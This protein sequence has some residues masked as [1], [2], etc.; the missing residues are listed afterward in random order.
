MVDLR[1]LV[2]AVAAAV[3]MSAAS[4]SSVKRVL[5]LERAFPADQKVELEVLKARDR[6][7]HSRIMQSFAGG[8]ADFPVVGTS[9]PYLAG[10]YFTKVKLG[11]PPREFNVQIDTGSDVLWV[12]CSSCNNCPRTSGLGVELNSFD[13]ANSSTVSSISCV[14]RRCA[15]IVQAASAKCSTQSNQCGYSFQYADGSGT[16]GFYVSDLLYL[17]TILGTSLIANS[18]APIVFGCSTSMSGDLTKS[19]SAVDGLFGFGQQ[20]LSVISQLSSHGITPKVFSHCLKGEGNGGGILVLGEIL[21]SRI[22]YTPLVPSQPHYSL[23][24]QSIAVNGQVLP[25]DPAV[26]TTSGNRRTI[27]DS[28]TTLAYLVEEAYD[29][30]V[31]AI[32][33]A[34]SQSARPIIS[35]GNQCYLVST[36]MA[37]I[38]PPVSINFAGSVS[39]VLRPENYLVHMGFIDGN[40]TWC[41]GFVKVK[42][43]GTTILGDLVLKDK[44]FVYDL[45]HQRIGWADHDCSLSVNVSITSGKDEFVNAGQLNVSSGSSSILLKQINKSNNALLLHTLAVVGLVFLRKCGGVQK[46]V[47]LRLAEVQQLRSVPGKHRSLYK[48]RCSCYA[49][50]YDDL[51]FPAESVID[52]RQS[53]IFI[54]ALRCIN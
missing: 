32:T 31:G 3:F 7:R 50:P 20:D 53:E 37:Q 14:D 27:V 11:S 33:A 51:Y 45:A 18:S 46:M 52:C 39:M 6:A 19:D 43:P 26:F 42:S 25:I 24:L 9:D 34:V 35:K 15:S 36:S 23:Y 21:D 54:A 40:A 8:I 10:L 28:G 12:T 47:A 2:M 29:P 13:A 16:A 22:V 38:F 41:I 1:F 49:A 48:R 4:G 5:T 17:D 30:F 44:I